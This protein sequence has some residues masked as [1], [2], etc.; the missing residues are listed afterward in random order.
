MTINGKKSVYAFAFKEKKG[1]RNSN[2]KKEFFSSLVNDGG[3]AF[4]EAIVELEKKSVVLMPHG[5]A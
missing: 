2:P 4:I 3:V 5:S 1:F